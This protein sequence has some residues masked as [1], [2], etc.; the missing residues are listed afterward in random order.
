MSRA[1][2]K[3]EKHRWL[4]Y[5]MV[6]PAFSIMV[7]VVVFPIVNTVARS[8]R[9]ADGQFTLTT[10]PISLPAPRRCKACCSPSPRLSPS[11]R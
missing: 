3:P 10:M 1:Y 9:T 4:P 11:W 7:L 8:F 6:L 5:L 2:G